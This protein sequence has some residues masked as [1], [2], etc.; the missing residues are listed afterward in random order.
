MNSPLTRRQERFYFPTEET[1]QA[2]AAELEADD[3]LTAVDY[4]PDEDEFPWLLRAAKPMSASEAETR[5]AEMEALMARHKPVACDTPG[6]FDPVTG[7]HPE[8]WPDSAVR[9]RN[10]RRAHAWTRDTARAAAQ[11]RY[12]SSS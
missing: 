11:C 5:D 3:F 2:A 1:A 6:W 10:L 9:R 8:F 4:R 12:Q 7:E